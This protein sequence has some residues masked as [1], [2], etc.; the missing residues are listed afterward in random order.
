MPTL[1]RF[2]LLPEKQV[3]LRP[4]SAPTQGW[5]LKLVAQLDTY[6]DDHW[7]TELHPGGTAPSAR[8]GYSVSPLYAP[9]NLPLWEEMALSRLDTT[10][11]RTAL[12]IHSGEPIALRVAVSDD[13]RAA[14][15]CAA[16][17]S[18]ELPRI[19]NTPC[20][21][22]ALPNP[23]NS[24]NVLTAT[25][26]RLADAPPARRFLLRFAT[27]TAF[28]SQ[29]DLLPRA[30]PERMWGSW[31]RVWQDL[32]GFVPPDSASVLEY[33]PRIAAY[34]LHT[35][36]ARLKGGLFIGFVGEMELSFRPDTPEPICRAAAA[37]ASIADF[38]GTG[39]KTGLGMGQ[40]RL[41]LD[42]N[43]PVRRTINNPR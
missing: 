26:E 21:L 30:E 28:F 37:V 36:T 13:A 41:F 33:L 12:L 39:A 32:A 3:I 11:D 4:D 16:L 43:P 17:P 20:H 35:E 40:T 7:A 8:R 25:W 34:E 9:E 14:A 10:R 29:G 15:L 42:S 24:T 1:L 38:F 19:G 27:P 31:L 5:F 18:L 2:L 6:R 23:N 22:L